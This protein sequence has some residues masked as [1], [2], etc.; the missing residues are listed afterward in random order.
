M[1]LREEH[2]PLLTLLSGFVENE[3]SEAEMAEL[4]SW[5]QRDADA[6]AIY[7]HYMA[8]QVDLTEQRAEADV[9]P[10]PEVVAC[11]PT[12]PFSRALMAAAA[13]AV[14][15]AGI[16]IGR[17]TN[18]GDPGDG[19]AVAVASRTDA[20]VAVVTQI[21]RG[22]PFADGAAVRVGSIVEPGR[23]SIA[24]GYAK[25]EFY[26]GA[27]V[28]VKGPAEMELISDNAM[29]LA[30]GV[31][32]ANVPP[33]AHGFLVKTAV[34]DVID[35]GTEFGITA[36]PD[37]GMRVRVYSGR[38]D[39][40]TIGSSDSAVVLKELEGLSVSMD[41][42]ATPWD[43][44][45]DPVV[46]GRALQEIVDEDRQFRYDLRHKS[47]QILRESPDAILL[48]S[49]FELAD[50]SRRVRNLVGNELASDGVFVGCTPGQGRWPGMKALHFDGPADRVR[51]DVQGDFP[52][53]TVAGWFN[54]RSLT[55]EYNGLV[56]AEGFE[57]RE[58]HWQIEDDGQLRLGVQSDTEMGGV[59]YVS[60]WA[61][62][63]SEFNRWVHLA[64]TYNMQ[65]R[66]V[67]FYADGEMVGEN[68]IELAVP[69]RL[70]QADIGNWSP[71]AHSTSKPFR[72]LDAKLDQLVIFQRELS[73]G[74]LA[75]L[76]ESGKTY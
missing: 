26:R 16:L 50:S 35:R 43:G 49:M 6:R 45:N 23:F 61:L 65:M 76:Y 57:P 17:Q 71:Q 9:L 22:E 18:D 37:S 55:N 40:E 42:V 48:Y 31:M 75:E 58:F 70:G 44:G 53:I 21:V 3:L 10:M 52:S 8:M 51:F 13:A 24:S 32:H 68:A 39:V 64:F 66:R 63:E 60:E 46:S 25:L 34:A 30:I 62:A 59:N 19:T 15:V 14:L 73:G 72:C 27:A 4:E 1:E 74:E 67:R 36:S 33:E 38:V 69:I 5:L 56:M 7:V 2:V 28:V 20:G 29:S 41:G 11:R 47:L 54:L 12:K